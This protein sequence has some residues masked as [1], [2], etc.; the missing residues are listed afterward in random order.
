MLSTQ[1]RRAGVHL[2]AVCDDTKVDRIEVVIR[3]LLLSMVNH[4]PSATDDTLFGQTCDV[5]KKRRPDFLWLGKDR[6]VIVEVDEKGGHGRNNYTP[7]CDFGWM[8]DMVAALNKL[9]S[10]GEWNDGRVP[11][12]H[13]FR[14]NPDEYDKGTVSLDSR[15]QALSGRI[16]DVLRMEI[17]DDLCLVPSVE[18]MYY[19]TKCNHHVDF[20]LKH[21]NSARVLHVK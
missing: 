2:C 21:P 5:V 3:P 17:D 6:C 16:H 8:M 19:H 12:V 14:F 9:Y 15:V 20:A 13:V 7:E 4:P 1:R 18:F 10:D 11:Y